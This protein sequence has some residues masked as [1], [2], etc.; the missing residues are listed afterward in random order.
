[1][2]H[3]INTQST[4]AVARSAQLTSARFDSEGLSNPMVNG[5][6]LG[7]GTIGQSNGRVVAYGMASRRSKH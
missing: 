1:M 6:I 2:A 3:Q 7:A 5:E 4:V